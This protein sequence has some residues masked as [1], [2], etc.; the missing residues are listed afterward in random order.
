SVACIDTQ[1]S[2]A[3]CADPHCHI[4]SEDE[5]GDTRFVQA[6]SIDSGTSSAGE[7]LRNAVIPVESGTRCDPEDPVPVAYERYDFGGT[8]AGRIAG[9]MLVDGEGIAVEAVKSVGGAEPHESRR[10]LGD[11]VDDRI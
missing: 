6:G 10:I 9:M 3:V 8:E 4:A 1:E 2:A 5:C 7:P 11:C